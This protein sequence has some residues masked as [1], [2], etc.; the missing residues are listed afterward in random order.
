MLL[1]RLIFISLVLALAVAAVASWGIERVRTRDR[2][3]A[4]E[5]IAASQNTDLIRARCEA[6]PNWFLAGP[7]EAAPSAALLAQPDGDVLAPRPDATPRP[8]EFFAYDVEHVGQSTAAPRMPQNIRNALRGGATSVT[9]T[10]QTAD[11]TGVVT[12]VSTGWSGPCAVLLFRMHPPP[13]QWMERVRIFGFV[14][15]GVFLVLLMV[16]WPIDR[17][18]R[19]LGGAMRASA[20]T[21]YLDPADVR[22]RDELASLGFA[23]NEAALDIRRLQTD[24][25]DREADFRRFVANVASEVDEPLRSSLSSADVVQVTEV[26]LHMSNLLTGARFRDAGSVAHKPVDVAE[27]ARVAAREFAPAMQRKG[28]QLDATRIDEGVT[29]HGDAAFLAQAVRNLLSN[30]LLREPAGGRIT[31]DLRRAM[32]SAWSLRVSDTGPDL[33]AAELR[34][35]NAVRRFRGDEGRGAGL[36]GDIGLSLAVV[37]EVCHRFGLQLAFRR[38]PTGG[39]E[40]ELTHPAVP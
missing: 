36:R 24:V 3:L 17:R 4:I 30:A 29:A 1:R 28:V 25:R 6:M 2:V 20:R 21:E 23:F 18:I 33:S 38:P 13:G 15:G 7:R 16:A 11:G 37:H 10:F 19:R 14:A 26:A 31:L 9:E 35:L 40:V 22:G 32:N 5:R 39:L 8:V 27:A 12:A 34:E